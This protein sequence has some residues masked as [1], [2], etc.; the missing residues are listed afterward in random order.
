MKITKRQL[1]RIIREEKT[2]LMNEQPTRRPDYKFNQGMQ[3][4][5]AP[6]ESVLEDL[7]VAVD[8]AIANATGQIDLDFQDGPLSSRQI[9]NFVIRSLQER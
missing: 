3:G 1:R 5:Y 7:M 9:V 8:E 4:E 6:G 2:R